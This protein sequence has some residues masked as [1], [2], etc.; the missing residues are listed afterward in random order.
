MWDWISCNLL[1]RHQESVV[2]E[3]ASIHLR[4]LKCGR[5]SDGW[6]LQEP[7]FALKPARPWRQA[8]LRAAPHHHS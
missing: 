6:Q 1:G 4:C 2:C 5:R 8:V 3:R 7:A